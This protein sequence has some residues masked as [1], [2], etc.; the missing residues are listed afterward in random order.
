MRESMI[1]IVREETESMKDYMKVLDS[2]ID[3]H[4][5]GVKQFCDIH[6]IPLTFEDISVEEGNYNGYNWCRA[7]AILGYL[8][9]QVTDSYTVVYLPVT[10][11]K[12]QY[13]WMR[14]QKS[15][16]RRI[17]E[18]LKVYSYQVVD[19]ELVEE[20]LVLLDD[21]DPVSILFE[22]LKSKKETKEEILDVPKVRNY[23][24]NCKFNS[25]M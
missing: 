20:R 1:I 10:I 13:Q 24:R 18:D 11:S 3:R 22:K 2:E 12:H 25:K 7:I 4:G 9:L 6:K 19:H 21:M 17:G 5:K 16:L 23:G 15:L 8:A 14:R